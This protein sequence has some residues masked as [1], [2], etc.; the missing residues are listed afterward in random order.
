MAFGP[1]S[2]FGCTPRPQAPGGLWIPVILTGR[3]GPAASYP[4]PREPLLLRETTPAHGAQ[5]L[6]QRYPGAGWPPHCEVGGERFLGSPGD[7]PG[8][9]QRCCFGDPSAVVHCG[10]ETNRAS[11]ATLGSATSCSEPLCTP[12]VS[13]RP[14]PWQGERAITIYGTVAPR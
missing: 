11:L 8:G 2:P 4:R 12:P 5:G 13:R 14:V 6:V 7:W 9:V 3:R 10:E 1:S